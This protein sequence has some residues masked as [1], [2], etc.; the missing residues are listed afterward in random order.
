MSAAPKIDFED[1]YDLQKEVNR[2]AYAA[3][4][5]LYARHKTRQ[6]S[7]AEF[8]IGIEMIWE[9]FSGLTSDG[10]FFGIVGEMRKEATLDSPLFEVRSFSIVRDGVQHVLIVMRNL[11]T[12]TVSAVDLKNG[13]VNQFPFDDSSENPPLESFTKFRAISDHCLS[14]GWKRGL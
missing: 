10:D 2:K 4:E 9:C 14:K 5:S 8:A 13:K 7:N 6:I 1:G 3:L 12:Y 11:K